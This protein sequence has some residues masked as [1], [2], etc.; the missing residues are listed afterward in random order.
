[1]PQ[2]R[3][4]AWRRRGC[5]RR[6]RR[7]IPRCSTA[8]RPP[9]WGMPSKPISV[10]RC[11]ASRRREG[12]TTAATHAD[13]GDRLA[14]ERR[15][16]DPFGQYLG[17]L[18]CDFLSCRCRGAPARR[19]GEGGGM[20]Q[21]VTRL[22]GTDGFSPHGFCLLWDPAILWLNAASDIVIG[23]AYYSIPL[24]L[25]YFVRKRKDLVF[26]WMF[27]LFAAFILACG[28]TH[29]FEVFT[30]WQPYY[31][32]QGLIKAATAVVSFATAVSL[33]PLVP[34]A[35]A[36]PAPTELRLANERL[37]Q[38]IRERKDALDRAHESEDR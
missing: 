25:I 34:R 20:E 24:A 14:V 38:Q 32:I 8:P 28:T 11:R 36:L 22:F 23:F 3:S 21:F 13:R 18:R 12:V 27:G 37:A 29:F 30:L 33:W 10:T 19:T 7:A 15:R 9:R 1:M 17:G 31:G 2:P 6:R 26:G 35:L 16:P 4:P 5:C